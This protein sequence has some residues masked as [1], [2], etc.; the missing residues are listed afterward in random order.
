MG[1]S[2]G[3][4]GKRLSTSELERDL[5]SLRG[6]FAVWPR[7]HVGFLCEVEM[8]WCPCTVLFSGLNHSYVLDQVSG[9]TL[10][11]AHEVRTINSHIL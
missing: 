8:V 4:A 3:E 6:F 1:W 9:S 11:E 5:L 10:I 7:R 2:K